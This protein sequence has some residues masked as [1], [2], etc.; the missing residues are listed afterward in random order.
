MDD[1]D[2]N[3]I[4]MD[5]VLERIEE[6]N[7]YGKVRLNCEDGRIH[8]YKVEESHLAEEVVQEHTNGLDADGGGG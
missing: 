2:K 8:S 3:R 7:L 4:V 5:A 6:G 1:A